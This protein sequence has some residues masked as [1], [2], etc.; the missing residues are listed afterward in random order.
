MILKGKV[1]YFVGAMKQI[2]SKKK[3]SK[4]E[5]EKIL[6]MIKYFKRRKKYMKYNEY[7]ARGYPIGTGVIEGACR[8]F[9]KDRMELAGMRW[10][11]VGAEAML[12]LRSIKINGFWNEYWEHYTAKRKIELYDFIDTELALAS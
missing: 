12:K 8:S 3:V 1:G 4:K 11:I 10:I 9:V 6:Q 5:G 2:V 7:L